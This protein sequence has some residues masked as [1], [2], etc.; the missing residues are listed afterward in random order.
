VQ[1]HDAGDLGDALRAHLG[2]IVEDAAE[3]IA[4]RE[5]IGLM[6]QVGPAG[7]HQIEAGQAVFLRNLL[8]AQMFLD[9]H[10]VIGAALHRRIIGQHHRQTARDAPDAAD[11]SRA[12]H[13]VAI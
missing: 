9:R 7:V 13:F 1:A 11:H 2:L 10:R 3:M 5:N 8:R 6:G 4:I 12:G